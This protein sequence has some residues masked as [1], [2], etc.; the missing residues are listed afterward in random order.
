MSRD[1]YH[2]LSHLPHIPHQQQPPKQQQ[3]RTCIPLDMLKSSLTSLS[4]CWHHNPSS[5]P[6]DPFEKKYTHTPTHA[7][8]SYLKTTTTRTMQTANDII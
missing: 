8:T 1:N 7:A 2:Q 5:N 6:R 4:R 3:T